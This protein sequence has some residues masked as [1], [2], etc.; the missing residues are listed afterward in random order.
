[1][2]RTMIWRYYTAW[3][4]GKRGGASGGRCPRRGR[5]PAPTRPGRQGRQTRPA[6]GGSREID[7]AARE[8]HG[9]TPGGQ[10]RDKA[11]RDHIAWIV[12][13]D[14]DSAG[15]DQRRDRNIK[16]D[17]TRPQPPQRPA[18]ATK[19][20]VWPDGNDRWSGRQETPVN[21]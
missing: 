9:N 3:R 21:P 4:R 14:N 8:T 5:A 15:R 17:M 11:G 1:M 16:Q 18:K 20:A 10:H 6:A 13:P 12:R 19:V 7:A 2:C